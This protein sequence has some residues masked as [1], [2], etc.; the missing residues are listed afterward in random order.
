MLQ[1]IFYDMYV[2]KYN[3]YIYL[4]FL[5]RAGPHTCHIMYLCI[6]RLPLVVRRLVSD[7][8]LGLL[9]RVSLNEHI[10]N[11]QANPNLHDIGADEIQDPSA[12]GM[13]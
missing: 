13:H 7:F 9:A 8:Q 2:Y 1:Y 11:Q 6:S 4:L 5:C 10:S 12:H 3:T